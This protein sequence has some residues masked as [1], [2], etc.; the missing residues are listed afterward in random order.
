[1][2]WGR[3]AGSFDKWWGVHQSFDSS[4]NK[5]GD[6]ADNHA[7]TSAR[8]NG[9][10]GGL[11]HDK[12]APGAAAYQRAAGKAFDYLSKRRLLSAPVMAADILLISALAIVSGLLHQHVLLGQPAGWSTYFNSGLVVGTLFCLIDAVFEQRRVLATSK[13]RDRLQNAF[14]S[15]PSACLVFVLLLYMLNAGN[16]GSMRGFILTFFSI[17]LAAVPLARMVL[18]PLTSR[19]TFQRVIYHEQAIIIGSPDAPQIAKLARE[20][21]DSSA[22]DPVVVT[23]DGAVGPEKWPNERKL[24]INRVLAAARVQGHGKIFLCAHN[25][26]LDRLSSIQRGL[27]IVPRTIYVVVDE[28]TASLLH[29][30][31]KPVADT[32]AVEVQKEPMSFV[33][34]GLKRLMD[35]LIALALTLMLAPLLALLALLVKASS[36]GPVIFRQTRTGYRGKIFKI[37]KFRS[38]TVTEDGNTIVQATRNDARV[39]PIGAFLRRTSLDE[40]PQLFNVVCG[41]MSLIGPR[42]HAVAHDELYAKIIENYSVR[43]HVMPGITGWAQVHG[44]RGETP[45]VDLM[46]RRIELDLWYA[47]NVTLRL[48]MQIFFR[49]F[50]EVFRQR[51]A[52]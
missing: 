32:I 49:T 13:G 31:I 44:L 10:G 20:L 11:L 14:M 29:N 7:A 41:E 5:T 38:M 35:L 12:A 37:C 36:P 50:Y 1:M 3:L 30:R 6:A 27:S 19:L 28:A 8:A 2:Q 4:L 43:H 15:W 17:G 25:I 40:L 16:T 48:D 21:R 47:R 24:L 18:P 52:Y 46:Y 45:T 22:L 33:Q 39:T 23:F 34:R 9:E 51:N 42:P 26:A